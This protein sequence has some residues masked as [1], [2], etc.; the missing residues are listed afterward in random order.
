MIVAQ[1]LRVN[2]A[3]QDLGLTMQGDIHTKRPGLHII[4][5]FSPSYYRLD[6]FWC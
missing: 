3:L 1:L 2:Q 5:T 4:I 6:Y